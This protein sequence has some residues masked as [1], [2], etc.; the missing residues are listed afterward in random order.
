MLNKELLL[1]SGGGG[2]LTVCYAPGLYFPIGWDLY[3]EGYGSI[4]RSGLIIPNAKVDFLYKLAYKRIT[5]STPDK[6][7]GVFN[8]TED[9]SGVTLVTEDI[10]GGE[11]IVY[12]YS[13]YLRVTA[14]PA[15]AYISFY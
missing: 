10:D 3:V 4:T 12:G 5:S 2:A 6:V 11:D 14:F 15:V 1:A 8:L 9:S 7:T 13:Y